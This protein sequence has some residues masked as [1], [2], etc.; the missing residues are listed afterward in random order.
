MEPR[1]QSYEA[2]REYRRKRDVYGR[3]ETNGEELQLRALSYNHELNNGPD[4]IPV[5]VHGNELWR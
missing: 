4:D 1:T 5:L 2:G 3:K